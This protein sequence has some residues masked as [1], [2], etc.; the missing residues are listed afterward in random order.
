V[1]KRQALDNADVPH[2]SYYAPGPKDL[3]CAIWNGS[4][5]D[6]DTL[7]N[8][9]D[10]GWWTSIALDGDGGLHIAYHDHTNGDLK[11]AYGVIPEPTTLVL[12][13]TGLVGLVGIVRRRR[14]T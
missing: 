6:I 4:S 2:I 8:V 12:L 14:R 5:W 1:Y 7:D 3:K 9:G 13:G 11:Y 10:V